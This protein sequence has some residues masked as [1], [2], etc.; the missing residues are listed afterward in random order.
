MM[1]YSGGGKR[2]ALGRFK[3][4]K[5]KRSMYLGATICIKRVA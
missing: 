4:V 5:A 2:D 1:R 3:R